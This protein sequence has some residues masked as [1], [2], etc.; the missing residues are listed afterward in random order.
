MCVHGGI[1]RA[2][3]SHPGINILNYIWKME[4]PIANDY[5]PMEEPLILN[6]LLWS[7]PVDLSDKK[8]VRAPELPPGFRTSYRGNDGPVTFEMETLDEFLKEYHLRML[9][10]AH[11]CVDKGCYVQNS[12]KMITVFST[13]G[14]DE[15]TASAL[16][17]HNGLV[18]LFKLDSGEGLGIR[19][20]YPY[21]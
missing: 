15:N 6:D 14:Y 8:C 1:P 9:V 20:C 11:E 18:R 16:L 10:R 12:C 2:F 3:R 5:I 19:G 4:K 13:S 21:N 7:D 17:F